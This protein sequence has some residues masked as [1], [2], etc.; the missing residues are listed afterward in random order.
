MPHAVQMLSLL[1]ENRPFNEPDVGEEEGVGG[2]VEAFTPELREKM[3][4]LE[5]ENQILRKRLDSAESSP[6]EGKGLGL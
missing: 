2:V 1:R 3:V 6:L 4:R 5:K